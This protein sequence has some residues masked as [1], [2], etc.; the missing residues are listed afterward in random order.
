[1]I[2]TMYA[3]VKSEAIEAE[4]CDDWQDYAKKI[5]A[6]HGKSVAAIIEAGLLLIEAK[7]DLNRGDFLLMFRTRKG[8]LKFSEDTAERYMAIARN[9]VLSNSAHW[10]DLPVSWRTLFELSRLPMQ[11]L[12]EAICDGRVNPEVRRSDVVKLL[13]SKVTG[14]NQSATVL[15]KLKKLWGAAD[16]DTQLD[17]I[18]WIKDATKNNNGEA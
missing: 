1:M 6:A 3:V 12:Q 4:V 8:P 9:K 15:D 18:T 14:I 10:A 5:T 7:E 2:N 11:K 17:F 16:Q 13:G